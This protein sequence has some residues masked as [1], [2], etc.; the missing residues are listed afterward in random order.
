MFL[1]KRVVWRAFHGGN[2]FRPAHTWAIPS[3][4]ELGSACAE[5][6]DICQT[7]LVSTNAPTWLACYDTQAQNRL[8][9]ASCKTVSP[10]RL[11][12]SCHCW[13]IATRCCQTGVATRDFICSRWILTTSAWM[14]PGYNSTMDIHLGSRLNV[15]LK[16]STS[17]ES[18]IDPSN[19]LEVLAAAKAPF[20]E[21][22]LP[23]EGWKCWKKSAKR[24]G[25]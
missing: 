1:A 22:M 24:I 3:W 14:T 7:Y 12:L 10:L 11:Q 17:I 15:R 20:V 2:K 25:H 6:L 16:W 4:H 5:V 21:K 19:S 23:C 8:Y 9:T 18:S 13:A